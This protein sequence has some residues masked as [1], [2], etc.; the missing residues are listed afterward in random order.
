MRYHIAIYS[1]PAD[2][3][4]NFRNSVQ[5]SQDSGDAIDINMPGCAYEKKRTE[6]LLGCPI[7]E[8]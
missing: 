3:Y 1:K 7:P 5:F 2:I 4:S 8:I 6:R